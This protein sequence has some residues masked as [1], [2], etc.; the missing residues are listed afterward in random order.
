MFAVTGCIDLTSPDD[1]LRGLTLRIF[2]DRTTVH[3]GDS[4]FIRAVLTNNAGEPM[5]FTDD[6]RVGCPLALSVR[7]PRGIN[8]YAGPLGVCSDSSSVG[9]PLRIL[10]GDS[11]LASGWWPGITYVSAASDVRGVT[12]P[13][14]PG[15][16]YV[17]GIVQWDLRHSTTAPDSVRI[18]V[19]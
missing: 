12:G 2:P 8:H 4:V 13:A 5:T 3:S 10:P 6:P 11:L 19:Q 9:S 16:Y 14:P 15:I 7:A 18:V 1:D 17:V